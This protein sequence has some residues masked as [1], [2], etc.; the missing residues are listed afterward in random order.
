[1]K[2][3]IVFLISFLAIM[4]VSCEDFFET[5]LELEIP[6][7]EEQIVVS[8]LL[9]N[10]RKKGIY[11]SKTVGINDDVEN[12]E[13]DNAEITLIAGNGESIQVMPSEPS[14]NY[15]DLNYELEEGVEF[16]PE[17]TY[18]LEVSTPDGKQA[19]CTVQMPSTPELISAKYRE[20]G[21]TTLDGDKLNAIDI[22]LKDKPSQ[23]NFYRVALYY[24]LNSFPTY[25]QSNDPAAEESSDYNSLILNDIQF[26]GEEYRLQILYYDNGAPD[27]DE[28]TVRL[29]SISK[30]QYR[31]DKL[32]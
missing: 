3:K 32:L 13:I 29:S 9:D 11:I 4:L 14:N 6:E 27:T 5:T 2:Y 17:E 10:D 12:T 28:Y 1:M 15:F 8:A 18:T 24:K 20:G 22:V 16:V 25:I 19:N 21:G 23:E 30:D 26:D 7:Y 31:F